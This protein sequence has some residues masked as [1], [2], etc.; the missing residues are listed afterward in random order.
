[1]PFTEESRREELEKLQQ[2]IRE[3]CPG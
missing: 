3:N 2:T 1:V